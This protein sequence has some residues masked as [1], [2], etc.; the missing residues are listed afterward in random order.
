MIK[1]FASY[2]MLLVLL[3][4]VLA[5]C[6]S[7]GTSANNSSQES[8]EDPS[9]GNDAANQE[10]IE[11]N[12]GHVGAPVS[13]Q[14][15]AAEIF[16]DLVEEKTGG[17]VNI[18][19]YNSAQLGDERELVEGIQMGTID[20]GIISS[21]LF[22]S[23]YEVMAAFE[24]P[25]LFENRDHVLAVNTG[26]IGRELLDTLEERANLKAVSIWDHGFRHITNSQR[27]I[28]EPEDLK[29]LQ[30][31]SPQ[32]PSY[33]IALD[34]LGAI[35]VPMAFN[36]LYVALDRGVVDGQHNPLMHVEGQ[37]FYE[38]Q[39]YLTVMDFAY[40]PNIVTFSNKVWEKLSDE[41]REQL[42][43]AANETATVW[44]EIAAEEDKQLLEDIQEKMNVLTTSNI[45]RDAFVEIVREQGFPK[46]EK[47]F[48][49]EFMEFLE[50]VT[51]VSY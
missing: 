37:R 35:P 17:S 18:K 8:S 41:Q 5:G 48:S 47:E 2:L 21:G 42:I 24:V 23:S 4:F 6:G 40:T 10:V 14:E 46:Y 12:V 51:N 16:A 44:S 49:S 36:E 13:P 20:G 27:P 45:N 50:K 29:G 43:K 28:A 33:D 31:R 3:M 39:D 19:I 9:S 7:D 15:G 22:A 26:E 38:V 32:V 30:I 1:R 25:F 34:A 11:I